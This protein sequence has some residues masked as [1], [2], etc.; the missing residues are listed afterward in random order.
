MAHTQQLHVPF[1]HKKTLFNFDLF[2][3]KSTASFTLL[4]KWYNVSAN[5]QVKE[6]NTLKMFLAQDWNI[7][8]QLLMQKQNAEFIL[9][10]FRKLG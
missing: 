6:S 9:S 5:L 1:V 10:E 2:T 7:N 4:G 8:S 3:G